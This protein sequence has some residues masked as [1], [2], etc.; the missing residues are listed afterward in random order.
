MCSSVGPWHFSSNGSTSLQLDKNEVIYLA[1]PCTKSSMSF[2]TVKHT[3]GSV[4]ITGIKRTDHLPANQGYYCSTNCSRKSGNSCVFISQYFVTT[5]YTGYPN[6]PIHGLPNCYFFSWNVI[7]LIYLSLFFTV[8]LYSWSSSVQLLLHLL[9][10]LFSLLPVFFLSLLYVC[11]SCQSSSSSLLCLSFLSS[12]CSSSSFIL[13]S[14]AFSSSLF[15]SS[16]FL[17][18]TFASLSTLLARVSFI[19]LSTSCSSSSSFSI[20][21]YLPISF[22]PPSSSCLPLGLPLSFSTVPILLSSAAYFPLP[23]FALI[24]FTSLL[25]LTILPTNQS[26]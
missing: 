11:I 1:I 12:S 9:L 15:S 24:P 2:L 18:F 16:A 5:P 10:S 17:Y 13:T 14:L 7:L 22:S 6:C 23:P 26:K 3:V 4:V 21:T 25:P 19:L 8:S 20:L